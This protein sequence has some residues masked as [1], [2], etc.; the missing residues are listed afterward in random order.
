[1]IRQDM[2]ADIIKDAEQKILEQIDLS[3]EKIVVLWGNNWN[4]GII[5]IA[6]SKITELYNRPCILISIQEQTGIASARSIKGFNLY[7]SL[8]KF[9]G[10]FTRFGGHEM[11]AGF[12]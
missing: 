8:K 9:S 10:L 3:T 5:G 6:A 1:R 7:G 2:E 4:Q 12:T 11:A